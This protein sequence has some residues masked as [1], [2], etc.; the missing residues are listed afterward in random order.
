MKLIW[1]RGRQ[2]KALMSH[3]SDRH[4]KGKEQLLSGRNDAFLVVVMVCFA[5]WPG[6]WAKQICFS[7]SHFIGEGEE[8]GP[9]PSTLVLC[10]I[11]SM[12]VSAISSYRLRAMC[13]DPRE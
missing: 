12:S 1:D 13:N 9:C 3:G 8:I 11:I 10:F 7:T 5:K 2:D 4:W 6:E